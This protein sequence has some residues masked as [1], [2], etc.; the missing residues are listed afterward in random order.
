MQTLFLKKNEERRIL[1]G[2]LWI[3]SN[4]I[5]TKLSPLKNFTPGEI[6]EIRTPNNKFLASGYINPQT[7]LCV[8]LLTTNPR[9]KINSDFFISRIKQAL[10]LRAICFTKPFYRLIFGESDQLPGFIVDRF[11]KIL[12]VQ[13][14]TAGAEKLKEIIVEALNQVIKP[15]AILLRNDSSIR[16]TENLPN[17]IEIAYGQVPEQIIL[18]ENGIS[19]IVTIKS[20]QKTGWFYDQRYNRTCLA[21]YVNNK[22]VL[23][24]FSYSGGFAINAALA[25]ANTVTCIDTSTTALELLKQNADLNNVSEKITGIASEAF[26][27]LKNLAN[28]RKLYEVIILDPPAFIKRQKDMQLG[29]EAYLRLHRQALRNLQPNGILLTTS[30]SLHLSRDMLLDI[31]RQAMIKEKRQIFILEQLHQSQDH[32]IHPAI[33]ETNYLKGFIARVL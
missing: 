1:A 16:K 27:V 10:E 15:E 14:N 5:D 13:L 11:N 19:F 24:V 18:E 32:P 25:S 30:C 22:N 7:L 12:V 20:G 28:D 21:R 8:R 23:D 4:E 29:I 33:A 2:H 6:I 26:N 17:Y 31:L 3:Y 9:E